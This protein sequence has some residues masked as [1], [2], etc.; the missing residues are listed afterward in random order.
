M[1]EKEGQFSN[2]RKNKNNFYLPIYNILS[3][4]NSSP[5]ERRK[6]LLSNII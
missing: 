5:I 3:F 2:Y 1:S 4:L 6:N